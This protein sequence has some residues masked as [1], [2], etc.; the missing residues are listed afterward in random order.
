MGALLLTAFWMGYGASLMLL[1]MVI[2]RKKEPVFAVAW[3]VAIVL[4]PTV[5]GILFFIFGTERIVSQGRRKLFFNEQMR[6]RLRD[7]EGDGSLTTPWCCWPDVRSTKNFWPTAC[8]S[9]NIG[10]VTCTRK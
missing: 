4:V 3:T 7:V 5:G 8:A 2:T 9:T 6:Q 1:P 10:P